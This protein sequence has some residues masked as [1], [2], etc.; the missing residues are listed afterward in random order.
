[1]ERPVLFQLAMAGVL[2]AL[3]AHLFAVYRR[4]AALLVLVPLGWLALTK[5][6]GTL[7]DA[8]PDYEVL[9]RSIVPGPVVIACGWVIVFLLGLEA[10]R[11]FAERF[12]QAR[13][14]RY[15]ARVFIVALYGALASIPVEMIGQT[16]GWW[17]WRVPTTVFPRPSWDDWFGVE[18]SFALI[19]LLAAGATKR[20]LWQFPLVFLTG[21]ILSGLIFKDI[22]SWRTIGVHPAFIAIPV[23]LA[24]PFLV[25][26]LEL[27]ERLRIGAP[28][29]RWR[30]API[31]SELVIVG[32]LCFYLLMR[33]HTEGLIYAVPYLAWIAAHRL[34]LRRTPPSPAT[35][36]DVPAL[37]TE[38]PAR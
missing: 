23:F 25:P 30:F 26:G 22:N 19:V 24:A 13:L 32:V 18:L 38:Q 5:E 37:A 6:L 16:L 10:S 28:A 21:L 33:G 31:V 7:H 2:V 3:V 9:L 35:D 20:F 27:H 15:F 14:D 34:L 11:V 36:E 17:R 12:P 8:T 29:S 1:M 4:V